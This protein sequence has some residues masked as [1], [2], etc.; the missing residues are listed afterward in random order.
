M[1]AG[2]D[3]TTNAA[4][5]RSRL[6]RNDVGY[7]GQ[8]PYGRRS[9][10]QQ[11]AAAARASGVGEAQIELVVAVRERDLALLVRIV[12]TRR[13]HG[14]AA[15]GSERHGCPR[16]WCPR[17]SVVDDAVRIDR[18]I[19]ILQIAARQ[20]DDVRD[21]LQIVRELGVRAAEHRGGRAG[22][23]PAEAHLVRVR[24]SRSSARCRSCGRCRRATCARRARANRSNTARPSSLRARSRSRR[25]RDRSPRRARRAR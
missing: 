4:V 3:G 18:Q 17:Q 7:A 13:G 24:P 22:A 14:V 19:Q 2:H 16:D 11:I 12:E 10:L 6:R 5:A 9:H 21:P 15:R 20:H 1:E 23:G 25:T 8:V